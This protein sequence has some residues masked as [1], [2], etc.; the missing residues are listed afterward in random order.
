MTDKSEVTFY[1]SHKPILRDGSYRLD[2]SHNLQILNQ[3]PQPAFPASSL[4]FEVAGPRFEIESD[5]IHSVYPPNGSRGDFRALLPTLVLNR[6]T[7]PWERSPTQSPTGD[8]SSAWLFLLLVDETDLAKGEDS[9][10]LVVEHA[11]LPIENVATKLVPPVS[12]DEIS[13]LPQ[14]INCLAVDHS[15][16]TRFPTDLADLEYFSYARIK[17]GEEEQAVILG[18]RLPPPGK[19]CTVYLVSLENFFSSPAEFDANSF[20]IPYLHKWD[21]YSEQ[22]YCITERALDNINSALPKLNV[23]LKPIKDTIYSGIESLLAALKGIGISSSG[24]E[25]QKI[26]ELAKQPGMTFHEVMSNLQGGFGPL[27]LSLETKNVLSLGT[28]ELTH[29]KTIK[30]YVGDVPF[31][32]TAWYRGPYVATPFDLTTA[33]PEFPS[34]SKVTQVPRQPESLA[35]NYTEGPPDLTYSSAFELG[36]LT[37]LNDVRFSV[38]LYRWK[39][40]IANTQHAK[41]TKHLAASDLLKK[42]PAPEEVVRAVENWKKL[43]GIPLRYLLPVS[44]LAPPES[45]RFFYID[46]SWINAF[47]SGAFSIGHTAKADFTPELQ[48]LLLPPANT[49]MGLLVHSFAVHA[50]PNFE[51]DITFVDGTKKTVTHS[52][53]DN[54]APNLACILEETHFDQLDFHLHHTK[55]HTGFL[56]EN[57]KYQKTVNGTEVPIPQPSDYID[58]DYVIR[59]AK[60]AGE[61]FNVTLV[62][63]FAAL[64]LEGKAKVAFKILQS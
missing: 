8:N 59:A 7:L 62:A 4:E 41:D 48:S 43:K 20:L 14:H 22:I 60:L 50:W 37:G 30:G 53:K 29:N 40:Q 24:G 34:S 10:A 27:S 17:P 9:Q 21:F 52:T 51:L 13:R 32:T 31:P 26:A 36:R 18:N 58:A 54:L 63:E 35:I 33:F 23:D 16:R 64:M 47:I 2:V 25:A 49:K 61:K 46:N 19:N 12:D 39:S 3:S 5:Q 6:S 42:D 1:A 44:S 56:F 15:L 11:N 28:A 45:I 57:N 55:T 38:A